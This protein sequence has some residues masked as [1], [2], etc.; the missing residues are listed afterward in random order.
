MPSCL[1][2]SNLHSSLAFLRFTSLQDIPGLRHAV[3]TR[4]GGSSAGAFT[5]LNLGYHVGDDASRVT[6]NRRR[7]ANV[8]GYDAGR[9]VAAQQVHGTEAEVVTDVYCGRGAFD[10]DSAVPETDALILHDQQVPVLIL[11]AD[12]APL[13]LVDPHQRVLAVVHAG[14]RGA[15]ARVAARTVARMHSTFSSRPEDIRAGIGPCLC[16][17]CFEVGPEVATVVSAV[18]PTAVIPAALH[19]NQMKPR[20]DLR[21]LLGYDLQSA[22]VPAEHIESLPHCPRCMPQMFFSHRGQNGVAGRFGLVAWWE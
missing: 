19:S 22:G 21:A 18:W 13:L 8:L 11:V 2:G 20:L 6:E 16:L 17:D 5:S 7:L 1:C 15:V 12:C 4:D 3:T 10:W 14:W 9:L